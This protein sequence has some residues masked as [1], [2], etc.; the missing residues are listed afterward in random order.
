M[1]N[2]TYL[3]TAN[4]R[5][6]YPCSADPD[7][8][9]EQQTIATDASAIPLMWMMLFREPDI[10]EQ[11]IPEHG[12]GTTPLS[13]PIAP[14]DVALSR[15]PTSL[16][17]FAAAFPEQRS[18]QAHAD[19]LASAISSAGR[20]F[21]TIE[22]VEVEYRISPEYFWPLFR[23]CLRG[24]DDPSCSIPDFSNTSFLQSIFRRQKRLSWKDSLS[25]ITTLR[26]EV[27]FPVADMLHPRGH[28]SDD[29]L[30]NISRLFGEALYRPV[31]WER[32][33]V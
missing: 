16:A 23:H 15:L 10:C 27:V 21:V 19:M 9:S 8:D 32:A 30:W 26:F 7:Y 14:T 29:D 11:Q 24:F 17:A 6:I 33:R 1:A 18:L 22:L 3:C 13:A 25:W 31:P 20:Q 2:C 12:G 28:Y 4:E 5:R